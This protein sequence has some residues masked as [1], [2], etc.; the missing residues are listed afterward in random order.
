MIL[1]EWSEA[2]VVYKACSS[3]WRT[4]LKA[5]LVLRNLKSYWYVW[6]ALIFAILPVV[7]FIVPYALYAKE[8][9]AK[10]WIGIPPLIASLAVLCFYCAVDKALAKKFKAV[11]D[12]HGILHYPFWSRRAYFAYT[13]FLQE[14]KDKKYSHEKVAKLSCFAEIAE[15]PEVLPV[16]PFQ[17]PL[18]IPLI[19]VLT[20]LSNELPRSKL[21][22]IKPP[23]ARSYGPPVWRGHTGSCVHSL[24]HSELTP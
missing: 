10:W 21:R 22:G 3:R 11:H 23:L 4:S 20:A 1:Q 24:E 16:R 19:G 14:L 17:H 6:A 15:L 12:E 18:I 7:L 8:D 9:I 5:I 13:L 2:L